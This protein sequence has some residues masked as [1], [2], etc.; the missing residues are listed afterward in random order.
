MC[1]SLQYLGVEYSIKISM[2]LY[3]N[4]SVHMQATTESHSHSHSCVSAAILN[5]ALY[6]EPVYSR[7]SYTKV[8]RCSHTGMSL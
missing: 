4:N 8:P 7:D 1:S 2:H 3:L 6:E 5:T